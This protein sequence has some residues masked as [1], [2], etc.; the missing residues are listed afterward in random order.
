[1]LL[2]C[3]YEY[4][5]NAGNGRSFGPEIEV[6]AKISDEWFVSANGA[7]TN[8]KITS[9][10]LA[11]VSLVAGSTSSCQTISNCI[12]PILNVPKETASLAL[13]Y[14]TNVL[15]NHR[16]TARIADIYVGTTYDE[17][18]YFAIPLASYSIANA[19]LGLSGDKW[20]AYLFVDNLANKVA[21]LTANNTSFQINIPQLVRYSTNQPR[22]LGTQVNYRF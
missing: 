16:L 6:N 4:N 20:S 19:R 1:L 11:L 7:Y 22:T 8:S 15:N 18:Y 13:T 14:T 21:E 5:A 3:G 12:V 17:S 10:S 2:S 9:P